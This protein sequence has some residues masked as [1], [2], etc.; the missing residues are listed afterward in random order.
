MRVG[1]WVPILL[2][3]LQMEAL[4][5]NASFGFSEVTHGAALVAAVLLLIARLV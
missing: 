3:Q 5:L 1:W 4:M 2:A